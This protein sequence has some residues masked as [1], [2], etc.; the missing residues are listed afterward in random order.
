MKCSANLLQTLCRNINVK[1]INVK[2]VFSETCVHAHRACLRADNFMNFDSFYS[3]SQLY[4]RAKPKKRM[5]NSVSFLLK[6]KMRG[7]L[8]G[9]TFSGTF[10]SQKYGKNSAAS[11]QK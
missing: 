8:M 1:Y 6:C 7:T 4:I 10:F 9:P 3:L 5:R 2:Y 11:K